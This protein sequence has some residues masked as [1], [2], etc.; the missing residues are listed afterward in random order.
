MVPS[1]LVSGVR[2]NVAV[3][4]NSTGQM[5]RSTRVIGKITQPMAKG[6]LYMQMET[7]TYI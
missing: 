7:L 4:E 6:D 2:V 1:T 3:E 5:V